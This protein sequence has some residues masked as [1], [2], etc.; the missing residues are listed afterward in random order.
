VGRK[1]LKGADM[2]RS[3]FTNKELLVVTVI[4]AVLFALLRL[5]FNFISTQS[6]RSLCAHR[7]QQFGVILWMYSN[8]EKQFPPAESWCDALMDD[9]KSKVLYSCP[10]VEDG[11]SSFA[12]NPY[13]EPNSPNDVVLVFE[14]KDGWNQYGGAELLNF[15]NHRGKGCNILFN[16]FSVRFI[17]PE[18]AGELNWGGEKK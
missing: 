10:T 8:D 4:I 1:V 7:L 17:K 9:A 3:G 12:I 18:E 5:L 11:N 14:S 15:D 2:K 6:P 13:C 16:N